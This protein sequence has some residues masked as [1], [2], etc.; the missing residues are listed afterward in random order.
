MQ[1]GDELRSKILRGYRVDM[2]RDLGGLIWVRVFLKG[3]QAACAMLVFTET[4]E[5]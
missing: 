2:E 1:G 3:E 4:V 5:A